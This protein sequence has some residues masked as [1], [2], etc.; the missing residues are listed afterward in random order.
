M[1]ANIVRLPGASRSLV[2]LVDSPASIR[3]VQH[4]ILISKQTYKALAAKA[5]LSHSTVGNIASGQTKMPRLETIIRILGAL[6]WVIQA[7]RDA[8]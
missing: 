2:T 7:R 4:E 5:Q 8:S 3:L 6:G 1:S